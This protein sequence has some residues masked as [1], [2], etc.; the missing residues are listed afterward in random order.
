[1]FV[2]TILREV[3]AAIREVEKEYEKR[4]EL[5]REGN[6]STDAND[7]RSS[8]RLENLLDFMFKSSVTQILLIFSYNL[9]VLWFPESFLM[10]L[11][12]NILSYGLDILRD[13]IL[14][15]L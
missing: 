1:M 13:W 8:H 12:F 9:M 3:H 2:I 4:I 6:D 11:G 15:T 10:S 7:I 5:I 14:T